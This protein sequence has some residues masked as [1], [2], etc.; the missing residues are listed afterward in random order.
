MTTLPQ[1]R[2][3]TARI[4]DHDPQRAATWR[5]VFQSDEVALRSPFP[6]FAMLPEGRGKTLIYDLDIEALTAEQR[7][8]LVLH[9][10]GRFNV[11]AEQVEAQLS[12]V[13]C[14]ILA[15]DVTVVVE[16]PWRWFDFD[17]DLRGEFDDEFGEFDDYDF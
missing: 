7:E 13:G 8:R 4:S 12:V 14:P 5:M 11:S 10:S 1:S 17:D 16:R 15:E 3:F 2:D 6:A 9:I